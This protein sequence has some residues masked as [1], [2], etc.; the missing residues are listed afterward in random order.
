M[1]LISKRSLFVASIALIVPV[2]WVYCFQS[3]QR[4]QITFLGYEDD[5]AGAIRAHFEMRNLSDRKS[6]MLGQ[7]PI[8]TN[9]SEGWKWSARPKVRC[10]SILGVCG[11]WQ[12][13]IL[14]PT[15]HAYWRVVSISHS[16]ATH[17]FVERL[18]WLVDWK[19]RPRRIRA[20]LWGSLSFSDPIPPAIEPYLRYKPPERKPEPASQ[21]E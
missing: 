18:S 19:F 2:V 8:Q 11:I 4:V 17:K 13:A 7:L 21:W 9:S 15:N 10:E 14:A 12:D 5:S 6:L 3:H 16:L 20:G 1:K